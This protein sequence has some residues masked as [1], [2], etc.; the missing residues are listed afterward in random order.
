MDLMRCGGRRLIL[1]VLVAPLFG[2]GAEARGEERVVPALPRGVADPELKVGYVASFNHTVVGLDLGSGKTV[3]ESRVEGVPLVVI[4]NRVLVL[5]ADPRKP[6]AGIIITTDPATGRLIWRSE[7]ILLPEWAT[8]APAPDHYFGHLVR[9]K[10]GALWLKWLA[11]ARQPG[12]KDPNHTASGTV[13]LDLQTHKV[14][15]LGADKM[16]PPDL[17]AGVSKELAKLAERRV[18]TPVGAESRVAVVGDLVVAVDAGKGPVVLRRW[19]RKTEK[20]LDPVVLVEGGPYRVT[21]FPES[22]VVLVRPAANGREARQA[23]IWGVFSLESGKRVARLAV[24]RNTAEPRILATRLFYAFEGPLD[25]GNPR[26]TTVPVVWQLRAIDLRAGET[27][28]VRPLEPLPWS[29]E[30]GSGDD[31]P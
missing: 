21:P 27:A 5:T 18:E 19:D 9:L 15:M 10:D 28:F 1:A 26:F 17:P 6:N 2:L 7:P 13:R 14:E 3:W 23:P 4:E 8:V 25:T 12:K 22:G 30:G 20:V 11:L 29:L 31:N 24:D 16:P